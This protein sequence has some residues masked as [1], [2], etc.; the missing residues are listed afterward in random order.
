M[1]QSPMKGSPQSPV[2][3][4]RRVLSPAKNIAS[5]VR[6][7]GS[8]HAPKWVFSPTVTGAPTQTPAVCLAQP[9]HVGMEA[10]GVQKKLQLPA[11]AIASSEPACCFNFM[12]KM[13]SPKSTKAG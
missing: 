11:K 9:G 1:V 12:G 6:R 8:T 3:S 4:A 10:E 7:A 5:P 13:A 2:G